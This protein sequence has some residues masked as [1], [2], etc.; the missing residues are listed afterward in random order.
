MIVIN[1]SYDCICSNIKAIIQIAIKLLSLNSILVEIRF[2]D[3]D[4]KFDNL[5]SPCDL[6]QDI[7]FAY[8]Q[9]YPS[10]NSRG[11][12]SYSLILIR[13]DR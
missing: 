1:F 8:M 5:F 12:I 7:D 2:I 9:V 6:C 4:T 3:I 13:D 11:C 10:I